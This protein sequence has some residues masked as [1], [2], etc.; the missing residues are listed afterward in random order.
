MAHV[1]A[2][3]VLA[4]L[5]A[6]TCQ[7]QT[8]VINYASPSA[9]VPGKVTE[10]TLHGAAL[11]NVTDVWTSFGGKASVVS[12]KKSASGD[13]AVLRIELPPEAPAQIGALRVATPGGAS[14][15]LLF[16]IDDLPS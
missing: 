5:L 3:A 14:N 6:A 7:A 12:E 2:H 10:V 4:S 15:L 16:M 8:P 1:T 11:G 9:A 13:V